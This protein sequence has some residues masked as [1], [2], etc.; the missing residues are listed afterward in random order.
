[1]ESFFYKSLIGKGI[2]DNKSVLKMIQLLRSIRNHQE[3]DAFVNMDEVILQL[4]D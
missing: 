3:K 2:R 4:N 1:M